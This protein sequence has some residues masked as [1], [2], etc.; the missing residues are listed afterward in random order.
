MDRYPDILE[1]ILHFDEDSDDE[2][3][4]LLAET[5][6]EEESR[7]KRRNKHRGSVPGYRIIRRGRVEG[8][9][10][11]YHDYSHRIVYMMLFFEGGFGWVVLFSFEL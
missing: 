9:E 10:R 1:D 2:W 6:R 4:M 3:D 7:S 11:L 5:K 8:H